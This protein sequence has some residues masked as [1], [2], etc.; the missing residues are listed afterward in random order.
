MQKKEVKFNVSLGQIMK[1]QHNH[2]AYKTS[3]NISKRVKIVKYYMQLVMQHIL[4]GGEYSFINGWGM[5]GIYKRKRRPKEKI[6]VAFGLSKVKGQK[7]D[8]LMPFRLDDIFEIIWYSPFITGAYFRFKAAEKSVRRKLC[9][10]LEKTTM[11][12]RPNPWVQNGN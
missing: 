3:L 5:I 9:V 8:A 1:E 12:Y 2:V 4:R 10:I 7:T 11:Q 6:R